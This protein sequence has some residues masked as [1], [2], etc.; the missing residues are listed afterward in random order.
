MHLFYYPALCVALAL[1]PPLHVVRPMPM[2]ETASPWSGRARRHSN[3]SDLVA[4][5]RDCECVRDHRATALAALIR[6]TRSRQ[7]ASA[8]IACPMAARLRLTPDDLVT[9]LGSNPSGAM[10]TN[11]AR[12]RLL[13]GTTQLLALLPHEEDVPVDDIRVEA[14]AVAA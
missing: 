5:R 14:L 11:G 9:T 6:Q 8:P 3:R 7:I 12:S 4:A 13:D 10:Q 1:R 2:F